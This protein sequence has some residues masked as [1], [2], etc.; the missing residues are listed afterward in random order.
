MKISIRPLKSKDHSD[1]NVIDIASQKQYLGDKWKTMTDKEKV[2]V[3]VSRKKD[4]AWHV[5]NGYCF[6]AEVDS[7]VLGFIYAYEIA[8]THTVYIEYI[9]VDPIIQG[10]GIGQKLLQAV[11]L[12]SRS[13][14]VKR[15]WSLIN[16]DNPRSRKF[17]KN[18][19]FVLKD[20]IEADYCL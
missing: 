18:A 10:R 12:R 17:H 8:N 2:D 13:R 15:V 4:F 3:L 16:I 1:I 9:A 11:I 20:R 14:D 19:G 6:V 5:A 7:S